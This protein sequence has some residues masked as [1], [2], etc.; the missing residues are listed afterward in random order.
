M[1]ALEAIRWRRGPPAS[2][3]LLDQR[4]LPLQTVYAD[5]DGPEA[6]WKAIKARCC[7]GC[8]LKLALLH[9][10]HLHIYSWE[11][12]VLLA[13]LQ[14]KG[15]TVVCR[16]DMAVRGAP[17]IAI[18]AALA[19]AA[20]LVNAG[21]RK[22]FASA[23]DVARHVKE[24]MAYLVTRCAACRVLHARASLPVRFLHCRTDTGSPEYHRLVPVHA[25]C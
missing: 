13:I 21:G 10:C 22:Q 23:A 2:L 7:S 18:A 15:L 25:W 4:L 12:R 24:Q 6:A 20:D 5:V 17:A 8:P 1:A 16:Q 14:C 19:L 3:Q 11:K 9:W